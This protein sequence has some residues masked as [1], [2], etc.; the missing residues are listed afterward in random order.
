MLGACDVQSFLLRALLTMQS[1]CFTQGRGK[2]MLS[3]HHAAHG[4]IPSRTALEANI[5]AIEDENAWS[6]SYINISPS[7]FFCS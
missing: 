2:H 7:A 1:T 4:N 5:P 6:E 3:I